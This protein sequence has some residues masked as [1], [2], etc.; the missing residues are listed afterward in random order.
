M[1]RASGAL[2]KTMETVAGEKPLRFA[3]SLMVT[4]SDLLDERFT[5]FFVAASSGISLFDCNGALFT[6]V[7]SAGTSNDS[8]SR[9]PRV[10]QAPNAIPSAI[11]ILPRIFAGT[12][13]L[14]HS[15]RQMKKPTIGG[16]KSTI[17][18]SRPR[19]K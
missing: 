9:K 16:K 4:A 18:F 17:F 13:R 8:C 3:T 5:R 19:T 11:Q 6:G 2:F 7:Y 10:F 15:A 12:V 14:H 1:Y